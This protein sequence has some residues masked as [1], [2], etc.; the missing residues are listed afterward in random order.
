MVQGRRRDVKWPKAAE[1]HFFYK[2][3]GLT[4]VGYIASA[5]D[6]HAT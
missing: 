3:A 5:E 6:F 4:C 1:D 2:C